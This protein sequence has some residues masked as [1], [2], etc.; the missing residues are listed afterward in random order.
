[1]FLL[2][3]DSRFLFVFLACQ[4]QIFFT[5]VVNI[6]IY[7]YSG[8]RF[9]LVRSDIWGYFGA[10]VELSPFFYTLHKIPIFFLSNLNLADMGG[11]VL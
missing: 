1:M 3:L 6:L 2:N 7:F 5:L 11:G 4:N 8:I 10:L 9:A